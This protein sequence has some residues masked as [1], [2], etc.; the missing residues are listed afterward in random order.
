VTLAL[1]H[2][3][4]GHSLRV[5]GDAGAAA[6]EFAVA[7]RLY[8]DTDDLH[9]AVA[10]Y[11]DVAGVRAETGDL[12]AARRAFGTARQLHLRAPDPVNSRRLEEMAELT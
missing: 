1:T 7:A 5:L 8:R 9:L 4:L 11:L 12:D 2:R 3:E 6:D 10:A